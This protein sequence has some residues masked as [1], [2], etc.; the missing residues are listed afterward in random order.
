MDNKCKSFLHGVLP[1]MLL[2][3]SVGQ[4]YAFTNFAADISAHIGASVKTV[5]W[6]FSLGIF[7]LGMGAAFFGKMVEKNIKMASVLGSFLFLAGMIVTQL[8]VV[9]KLWQL[10][11]LGY[12]VLIGLG[13][14][15]IYITPVKTMMM[16]FPDKKA[17]A[18]AIPIIFFGLG[19]TLATFLYTKFISFGVTNV[20]SLF[21][22]FYVFPLLVGIHLLKKPEGYDAATATG[23]ASFKYLDLLNE[24]FFIAA[25]FFMFF[26][27]A[28]GLCIIPLA[29]SLMAS[30]FIGYKAATITLF[31]ALAGVF[32]GG[33][34]LVYAWASDKLDRRTK[35]LFAIAGDSIIALL[36]C[37]FWPSAFG[38]SMLLIN[39]CYGAGF[40]VIPGILSD[41]FG[42]SDISKIHGAVL[43]A[44][45]VAG[46]VGNQVALLVLDHSSILC[47]FIFIACVHLGNM[48]TSVWSMDREMK[49]IEKDKELD[50]I[51]E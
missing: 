23:S 49:K 34:R 27:I 48:L 9:F 31:I 24:P 25:W 16:W 35:I 15:I 12:G 46:L 20:F 3:V 17:L 38:V 18:S 40:S 26:N 33:G 10:V 30:E 44:W 19:S 4:I 41:R 39:M 13:T 2:A 32:N 47:L 6:A 50:E 36:L 51:A 21:A 11:L 7:F 45:G 28:A 37:I 43:S 1:A 5:Q 29:K 14:G 8:G 22:V 42:M